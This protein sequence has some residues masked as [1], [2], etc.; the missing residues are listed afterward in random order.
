MKMLLLFLLLFFIAW[1]FVKCLAWYFS[2]KMI[3]PKIPI[4]KYF[5]KFFTVSLMWFGLI[6]LFIFG[7]SFFLNSQAA[8]VNAGT[9]TTVMWVLLLILGFFVFTGYAL[10]P[11]ERTFKKMFTLPIKNFKRMFMSYTISMLC[12]I[13]ALGLPIYFGKYYPIFG[14]LTLLFLGLPLL[15][16]GRLNIIVA[17][18]RKK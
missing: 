9:I 1:I 17:S 4:G 7:S 15:A 6:I 13:I 16:F 18:W 2:H 10:I 3:Y 14:L 12:L 11:A 8:M 5:G